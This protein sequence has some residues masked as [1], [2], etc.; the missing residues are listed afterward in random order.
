MT[1]EEL[2]QKRKEV[3]DDVEAADAAYDAREEDESSV[4]EPA[5]VD[6]DDDDDQEDDGPSQPSG[7]SPTH[8][9]GSA[10]DGEERLAR[11]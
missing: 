2:R 4:D 3:E 7:A 9:N 10:V 1:P 5:A 8:A 6:D 11:W